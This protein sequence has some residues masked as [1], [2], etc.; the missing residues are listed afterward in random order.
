MVVESK[1]SAPTYT[2][3][4]LFYSRDSLAASSAA[5]FFA[6]CTETDC[7]IRTKFPIDDGAYPGIYQRVGLGLQPVFNWFINGSFPLERVPREAGL[8]K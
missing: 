2:Y 5:A 8:L 6:A 1:L 7:L 3:M 4:S